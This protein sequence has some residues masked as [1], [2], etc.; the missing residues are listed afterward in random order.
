MM[1]H[2]R[3]KYV[4]LLALLIKTEAAVPC[5]PTGVQK[6]LRY[7]NL[8]SVPNNVLRSNLP[9]STVDLRNNYLSY[10]DPVVDFYNSSCGTL[11]LS[12]N[13]FTEVPDIPNLADV[14]QDLYLDYNNISYVNSTI[15]ERYKALYSISV[16]NNIIAAFPDFKPTIKFGRVQMNNNKLLEYPYWPRAGKNITFITLNGNKFSKITV[17]Q[18]NNFPKLTSL[19][20]ENMT[21]PTMPNICNLQSTFTAFYLRFNK[22]VCDCRLLWLKYSPRIPQTNTMLTCVQPENLVG[23]AWKN[24]NASQLTCSG[25]IIVWGLHE[26][27]IS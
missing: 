9:D 12:N 26:R 27:T 6:N 14:L 25:N 20:M 2:F 21:I 5:F 19:T 7:C 24:I 23:I 17:E 1:K 10:I 18:L 11:F 4:I 3:L 16:T 8:T 22:I 15:I 13:Y